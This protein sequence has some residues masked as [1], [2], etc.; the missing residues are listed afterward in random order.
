MAAPRRPALSLPL[1]T[2]R[3]ALREFGAD[4]LE[5]M[6]G[7]GSNPRVTRHM[8][9]A[10]DTPLA[11]RRHLAAV[12]RQQADP[13]RRA[14]ELAVTRRADGQVVGAC[15]LSLLPGH[16]ADLGYVLAEEHWGQGYGT[17]LLQALVAAA[18]TELGRRRVQCTIAPRNARSIRVAEKAGLQWQA[19]L[20]DHART[21]GRSW[22]V[23]LYALTR[24]EWQA[25]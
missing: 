11:A 3:L 19:T 4:D 15:D 7:Y 22:D 24:E 25:R 13:R 14:W 8:L 16:E 5:A 10:P 18:F 1:A 17:E 21:R 12:L 6:L 20:R 23:E 9:F 2:P